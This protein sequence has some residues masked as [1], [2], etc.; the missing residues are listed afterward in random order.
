MKRL[1]L[2]LFCCVSIS[3][4][5]CTTAVVSGKYTPNGRPMIWKL[6]DGNCAI[7]NRLK[8]KWYFLRMENTTI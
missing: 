4:W 5:A 2:L 1:F 7:P 3:V 8:T 6:R